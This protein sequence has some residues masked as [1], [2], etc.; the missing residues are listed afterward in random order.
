MGAFRG[1]ISASKSL[2]NRWLI[3]Q[4]FSSKVTLTGRSNADDVRLMSA[5]LE[6]FRAG[7]TEFDCGE[8]GTVLRFLAFR[9]SRA[10]GRFRLRGVGR[11]LSRPQAALVEVLAQLGVRAMVEGDALVIEGQGWQRPSAPIT[12]DRSQSSQF[13][14]GLLLNAWDLPF[15]LPVQG[16]GVAV[17]DSYLKM[18]RKTV[19]AAGMKL[20]GAVG[21]GFEVLPNQHPRAN[22]IVIEPDFSSLFAVAAL[23]AVNGEAIIE[24]VSGELK[25]NSLQPDVLGLELLER[26]GASVEW[27]RP[28]WKGP[29]VPVTVKGA[30]TLKAVQA[31]LLEVPDLFPVLAALCARAHGVSELRNAPQLIHKESDR[32]SALEEWLRLLG[33]QVER[34]EGGLRIHGRVPNPKDSLVPLDPRGDHRLFMAATTLRAVG[35]PVE[36]LHPDVCSKS[37]PEYPEIARGLLA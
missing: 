8:A 4:S 37:F 35:F 30:P 16:T 6:A 25:T 11:L 29:S 5:A 3:I 28:H 14:S 34:I 24:G 36:P 17:S 1:P 26:M 27:P 21:G 32:L 15:A 10:P 31:D 7:R 13:L 2:F 33:V 20:S 19:L 9:V 22:Q 12:V 23:A 18:T